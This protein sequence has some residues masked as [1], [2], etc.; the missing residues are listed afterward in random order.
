MRAATAGGREL[1]SYLDRYVTGV[2][3][4]GFYRREVGEDRLARLAS[5]SDSVESWKELFS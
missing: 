5:W 1:S 2:T 4:E 3:D